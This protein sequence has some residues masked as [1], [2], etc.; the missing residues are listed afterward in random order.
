[1]VFSRVPRGISWF[2][3][4]FIATVDILFANQWMIANV[5]SNVFT[6]DSGRQANTAPSYDSYP[7]TWTAE[8][9]G[10][11]LEE[12][13]DWQRKVLFPKHH[14]E[15]PQRNVK[16]F[17]S[18]ERRSGMIYYE[19]TGKTGLQYSTLSLDFASI[20]EG[21]D[22]EFLTRMFAANPEDFL[23]AQVVEKRNGFY[24]INTVSPV[25]SFL[26]VQNANLPGW[27]AR[28]VMDDESVDAKIHPWCN[29][30]QAIEIP[31]GKWTVELTYHPKAFCSGCMDK[32]RRLEYSWAVGHCSM[33]QNQPPRVSVRFPRL[34]RPDH[35]TVN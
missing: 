1:M 14:L 8:S 25:D 7:P 15:I 12:I 35:H 23:P 28:V 19:Q 34:T 16:S 22:H 26:C 27:D 5:D 32:W 2:T 4:S 13:V 21:R 10:N 24:R 31:A 17:S 33:V 18:I 30:L 29:S 20:F 11:R 9:S 6:R 3:L